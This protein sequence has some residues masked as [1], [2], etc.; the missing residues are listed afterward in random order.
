[1]TREDTWGDP[2]HSILPAT[3]P[4]DAAVLVLRSFDVREAERQLIRRA[5]ERAGNNRTAAATLL[6]MHVRTLRRKL[7]VMDR[8]A[9]VAR[10]E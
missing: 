8:E 2:R 5:L 4:T 10:S 7:R 3:L 9:A 6:G 1:M